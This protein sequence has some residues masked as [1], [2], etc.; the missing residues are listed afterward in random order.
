MGKVY[1]PVNGIRRELGL[2]LLSLIRPAK[3]ATLSSLMFRFSMDS[4]SFRQRRW[5]YPTVMSVA[6][7]KK[8][9]NA[10]L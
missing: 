9:N 4:K 3:R 6:P 5:C 7:A 8:S 10:H 2:C 1:K